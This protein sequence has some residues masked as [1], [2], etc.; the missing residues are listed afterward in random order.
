MLYDVQKEQAL[1]KRLDVAIR[2]RDDAIMITGGCPHHDKEVAKRR[3]AL[4]KHQK[5]MMVGGA[6]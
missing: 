6:A 5:A 1:K 4:E 3:K 2:L